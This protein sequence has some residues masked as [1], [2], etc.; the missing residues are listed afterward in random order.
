MAEELPVAE[1][2]FV[3]RKLV[4]DHSGGLVAREDLLGGPV[5]GDNAY[6]S[7]YTGRPRATRSEW[8]RATDE[9]DHVLV[10]LSPLY[11]EDDG[12]RTI[13][14][15]EVGQEHPHLLNVGQCTHRSF[16]LS[17]DYTEALIE[18]VL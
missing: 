14:W 8:R 12:F 11:H 18:R 15:A 1:R 6:I 3:V 5:S 17:G 13:L 16:A 4:S 7:A 2:R 10:P 9:A